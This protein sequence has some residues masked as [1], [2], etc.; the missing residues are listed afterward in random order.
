MCKTNPSN[1][2]GG[3]C[4]FYLAKSF[5][6]ISPV[7]QMLKC[8]IDCTKKTAFRDKKLILST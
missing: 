8:K 4:I 1:K 6:C 7:L 2:K 5:L 3:N